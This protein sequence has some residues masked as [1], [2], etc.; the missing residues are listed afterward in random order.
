MAFTAFA[1]LVVEKLIQL[2][3][4]LVFVI[5][6][7]H[8]GNVCQSAAGGITLFT[9]WK[10]FRCQLERNL[11]GRP[12]AAK[13]YNIESDCKSELKINVFPNRLLFPVLT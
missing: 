13:E 3:H 4:V 5:A 12:P 10:H 6:V 2:H 11:I 8:L 1:R 9:L 7:I